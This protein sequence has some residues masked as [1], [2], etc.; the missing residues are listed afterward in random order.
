MSSRCD[1]NL[2]NFMGFFREYI[3]YIGSMPPSE[4][5]APPPTTSRN[6]LCYALLSGTF[7]Q[8]VRCSVHRSYPTLRHDVISNVNVKTLN[9][10]KALKYKRGIRQSREQRIRTNASCAWTDSELWSE[11]FQCFS[12]K[13]DDIKLR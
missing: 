7:V 9:G 11:L 4:G 6:T 12:V 5:M 3:K 2:F 10:N 8:S 13:I 1:Q